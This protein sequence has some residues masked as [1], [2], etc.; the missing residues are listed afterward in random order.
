LKTKYE[1]HELRTEDK[2]RYTR[3]L[4]K[5]N[6]EFKRNERETLDKWLKKKLQENPNYWKEINDK[7]RW[8]YK[9]WTCDNCLICGRFIP[10]FSHNYCSKCGRQGFERQRLRILIERGLNYD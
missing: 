3:L 6:P 4:R 7:R 9:I 8:K 10:K 2:N 1:F 5:T